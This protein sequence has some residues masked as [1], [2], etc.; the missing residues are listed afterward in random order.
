[1][2]GTWA[3][4]RRRRLVIGAA[5]VLLAAFGVF[6]LVTEI[7]ASRLLALT[8][9]LVVALVLHDAVLSPT[10]V[11][12]GVLLRKVPARA[13]ASVQGALVAGGIV[14]VVALPMIYRA[15]LQPRV[16]ALL[17]QDF[18]VNLAVLLGVI[19]VAAVLA[20]LRRALRGCHGTGP[21]GTTDDRPPETVSPAAE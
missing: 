7:P 16:K 12:V 13:R 10:I 19:S 4:I 14:T 5:G 3:G 1:M 20:Y 18:R 17:D 6:R 9:W 11:G 8:S 15:G 2:S 21:V